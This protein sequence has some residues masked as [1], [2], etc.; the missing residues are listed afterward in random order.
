MEK[1]IEAN[2]ERREAVVRKLR[3]NTVA[4]EQRQR[5]R[6]ILELAEAY[7]DALP[8]DPYA[9]DHDSVREELM[10][11]QEIVRRIL[12]LEQLRGRP[13][14]VCET[15]RV[16]R[17]TDNEIVAEAMIAMAARY[18]NDANEVPYEIT[19]QVNGREIKTS[20][21][22]REPNDAMVE[23]ESRKK[24]DDNNNN[25]KVTEILG[26]AIPSTSG[27]A[28]LAKANTEPRIIYSDDDD[29]DDDDENGDE[30]RDNVDQDDVDE[31]DDDKSGAVNKLENVDDEHNDDDAK[32]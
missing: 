13:N 30:D 9:S 6:L 16:K 22:I 29:D 20:A 14:N 32:D 12:Y 18:A 10:E 7:A 4:E 25:D 21:R 15:V 1:R 17:E 19:I 26:N 8:T 27:F 31:G 3:N 24:V 28:E 11:N 2:R 5:A 23:V